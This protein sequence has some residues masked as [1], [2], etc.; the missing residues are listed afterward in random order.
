MPKERP[1]AG[2]AIDTILVEIPVVSVEDIARLEAVV[3]TLK[4][5]VL[6]NVT[7]FLSS[8]Q[9]SF[10]PEETSS[11]T[12]EGAK[13]RLVEENEMPAKKNGECLHCKQQMAILVSKF[14]A[15]ERRANLCE[16]TLREVGAILRAQ[17]NLRNSLTELV[18]KALEELRR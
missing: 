7:R 13:L 3:A 5:Q 9:R 2:V 14:M 15:E 4:Q 8:E 6:G 12:T 11:V 17:S 16:G 18:G 10:L 1:P